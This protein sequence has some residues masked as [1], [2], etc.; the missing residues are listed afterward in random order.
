MMVTAYN[1]ELKD[2][3]FHD[4]H[5]IPDSTPPVNPHR[6]DPETVDKIKRSSQY[7]QS[8]QWY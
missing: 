6:A 7:W 5:L 3:S 8:Q 1:L 2:T 4:M